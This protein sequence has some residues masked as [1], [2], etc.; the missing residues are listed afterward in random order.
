MSFDDY[1]N[2]LTRRPLWLVKLYLDQCQNTFGEDCFN[3]ENIY[4]E[5]S[6]HYFPLSAP[7]QML[8][9]MLG[10]GFQITTR[11]RITKIKIKC[12]SET[13]GTL[14]ITCKIAYS[15]EPD[16]GQLPPDF[17]LAESTIETQLT[18]YQDTWLEFDFDLSVSE[19]DYWFGL[20]VEDSSEIQFLQVYYSDTNPYPGGYMSYRTG[21]TWNDD[22]NSDLT[23]IMEGEAD[24]GGRNCYYTYPTCLD[25]SKYVKG[26]YTWKFTSRELTISGAFPYVERINYIPIEIDPKSNVSRRGNME[27]EFADDNPLFYAVPNKNPSPVEQ[28]G[29]FWKNLLARNPNYYHRIVEVYLGFKGLSEA[30][31]RLYFRGLIEKIE[32]KGS[33]AVLTAKDLLKSLDQQSHIKASDRCKLA[34]DYT[35]GSNCYVYY[36]QELPDWGIIKTEDGK[37]IK[38]NGKTGPD[39]NGKWTLQ[40]ANYCFGGSG[41]ASAG[42][43]VRQVLV[44]ARDNSGIGDGLPLDWIVMDLLCNRAG[45]NP[46]YFEMVESGDTLASDITAGASSIPV[47][48]PDLFPDTG[49]IKIDNELIVYRGKSGNNLDTTAGNPCPIFYKHHRGAFGTT[50]SSHTAGAK[51]YFPQITWEVSNWARGNL[52][53]TEIVE[54]RKVQE[55]I[56][57]LSGQALFY[58]W[59]NEN[60]KIDF[61]LFS[62]PRPGES[63]IGINDEKNIVLDSLSWENDP[64]I[65]ASRVIV[66]YAPTKE[67]PGKNPENYSLAHMLVEED[68]ENEYWLGE[69]KA[70][71]FYAGWIYRETE[72]SSLA[73]KYL[74]NYKYGARKLNFQLELKDLDLEVGDIFRINTG[75]L[76]LSDGVSH[77]QLLAIVLKKKFRSPGKI[78]ISA[79]EQKLDYKYGYISPDNPSLYAGITGTSTTIQLQLTGNTFQNED[80]A[81]SGFIRLYDGVNDEII[82]YSSKTYNSDNMIL[83]LNNCQRGQLGTSPDSFSAG[84]MAILMFAGASDTAKNNLWAW[85]GNSNNLLDSDGNGTNETEGYLIF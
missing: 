35:G 77:D 78:E 33:R 69:V 39:E 28:G 15:R 49:I 56:N 40:N 54:P 53:R 66:Y 26:T 20:V 52:Y 41:T 61:W 31:F 84:T 24:T 60:S 27:I 75:K 8:Y 1:K 79:I 38:F 73:S 12:F 47:N 14:T 67:N 25:T 36:G 70:K 11:G 76:L 57:E 59:Q 2:A 82:S 55:L 50:A 10:N 32:L 17:Y 68:V 23:F 42:K 5:Q 19:R 83:T 62:P 37:Y 43:K 3:F 72:A 48:N 9:S 6:N 85:Q 34:Q 44:Y 64:E 16:M 13:D 71:V 18:A 65:L 29:T 7:N 45:I 21:G 30:D 51:I 74:L 81:E 63:V 22:L 80:F 4:Q 46:D 58:I